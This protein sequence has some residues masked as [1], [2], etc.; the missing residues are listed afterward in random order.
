VLCRSGLKS[1]AHLNIPSGSANFIFKASDFAGELS[2]RLQHAVIDV[3]LRDLQLGIFDES[4]GGRYGH[5]RTW[6]VGRKACGPGMRPSWT[7]E[8]NRSEIEVVKISKP[9]SR[10]VVKVLLHNG[11]ML[12]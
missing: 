8:V 5:E 10:R 11:A 2:D 7:A 3:A 12:R 1:P 9:R 6:M 4:F